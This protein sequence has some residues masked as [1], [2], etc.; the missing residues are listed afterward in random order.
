LAISLSLVSPD[1][2]QNIN[3]TLRQAGQLAQ[4]LSKEQFAVS[5]KGPGD[6]VT[7]VDV[8]VDQLLTQKF[9]TWFPAD[10]IITEENAE[11]RLRF[12]HPKSR[13]WLIDPIDGTDD[14]IHGRGGY[15][16]MVGLLVD[17]HPQAG[18]VYHPQIDQLYFGGPGWGVFTATGDREPKSLPLQ[19]PA[20]PTAGFCPIMIGDKDLRVYGGSITAEIPTAQFYTLGSFG[21][22]VMQVVA[23]KAG[24]YLYLNLRVKLW[25]TTGPL[26]LAKAAGLVCCDLQGQPLRFSPDAIAADSLAH[27][28]MIIVGWPSYVEALLPQLQTA[29]QRV[30]GYGETKPLKLDL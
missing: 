25:D 28:Q 22:K 14:F 18:W 8:Q 11:S 15:A 12:G 4:Q 21:L 19:P 16:V 7:S 17:N 30:Q 23:A 20:P 10:G 1:Q 29:V 5:Q 26:A 2:L 9:Q 13:L 6:F 24:L 3:R 27:E